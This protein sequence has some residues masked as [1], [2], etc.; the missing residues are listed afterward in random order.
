MKKL[1]LALSATVLLT[2]CIDKT[3]LSAQSSRPARGNPDAGVTVLEFADI[4]CPACRAAHELVSKPL[5]EAQGQ[6]IR[7][8]FKHFPLQ[9]IHR[10][11]MEAAEASECAADQGKFWEFVDMAYEKQD[12]LSSS[13]I[14]DWGKALNLDEELFDRCI[15]S[16]VKR[17]FVLSEYEE[18]TAGGVRGTPTF[19]VNGKQVQSTV[20]ELTKAIN[21]AASGA[22]ARL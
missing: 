12:Q 14:R 5:L 3:G 7:F 13:A 10:F 19:F 16:H 11:A 6:R 21:E 9:Q 8:V 4:Q 1:L 18:G 2:A 20:E 22:G 15:R 17:Q